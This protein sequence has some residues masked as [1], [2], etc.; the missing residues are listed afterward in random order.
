MSPDRSAAEPPHSLSGSASFDDGL[1]EGWLRALPPV[2]TTVRSA[3][4]WARPSD[5]QRSVKRSPWS[6]ACESS[7]KIRSASNC[8]PTTISSS[9]GSNQPS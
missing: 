4:T 9:E 7:W 6:Q 5:T 1:T 8:S 3:T 2:A